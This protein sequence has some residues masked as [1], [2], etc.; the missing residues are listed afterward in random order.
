MMKLEAIAFDING[1]LIDIRTDE[2]NPAL[3]RDLTKFLIYE[4]IDISSE[5]LREFYF[6]ELHNQLDNGER[7]PEFHAE[8]IFSK[9]LGKFGK[10]S[11]EK[12]K[13]LTNLYRSLSLERLLPYPG[14]LELLESLYTKIP[15]FAISDGQVAYANAELNYCGISKYFDSITIS[16]S[17]NYRKPDPRM[18]LAPLENR[19]IAPENVLYIGDN[20]FTDIYGAQIV[21]MYTALLLHGRDPEDLEVEPDFIVKDLFELQSIVQQLI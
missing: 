9:L 12:A 4:G 19:G 3:Y 15:L 21:G 18:F 6:E 14:A 2:G 8:Q 1:T 10:Y 16:E 5:E 11:R 17:G 13:M 20:P 7:Y